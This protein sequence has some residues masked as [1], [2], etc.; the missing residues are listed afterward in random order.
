MPKTTAGLLAAIMLATT[1]SG[2]MAQSL[3]WRISETAGAV[4]IRHGT[5]ST[6]A[7][8][9]AML[10]P[11]DAVTTGAGGRAVLVH[12]RDFVTVSANSRVSVPIAEEAT[13][14]VKIVQDLGN[15][16]FKIQKLGVPHF[17]VKTPYLAAVV[18]GTTFSV[19]VDRAGTSLQVVEGAVEVATLD[20]GAR[21]LIR[22]GSVASI[23]AGDLFR[24]QVHGDGD[25]TI[26][27]PAR[28]AATGAATPVATTAV[29][30]SEPALPADTIVAESPAAPQEIGEA[31]S[32]KPIDLAAM[33]GGMMTG[34]TAAVSATLL[35]AV[36]ADLVR[37][38]APDPTQ[39][40][41]PPVAEPA[42]TPVAEAPPS[43]PPPE[44]ATATPPP[45]PAE[46]ASTP[47]PAPTSEVTPPPVEVAT[48]LPPPAPP[49]PPL[50]DP[51][52]GPDVVTAQPGN[53]AG[54]AADDA[55]KAADDAA[56]TADKA[57]KDAAKAA[58]DAAKA[59]DKAAKDAAKAADDVS[60]G[61]ADD[62]AKAAAKDAE[63][64]AKDAAKQAKDDALADL[65]KKLT[66]LGKQMSGKDD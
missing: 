5:T 8:R 47:P 49:P 42:A 43:A 50:V 41:A 31:I 24:L 7:T 44:V 37:P 27:S 1:S 6:P 29:A 58:D 15:A 63:K 16:I 10:A 45:P 66:K 35:A 20:G 33:T 51:T 3:T 48:A 22:P 30:S 46:V 61:K 12:D 56:K 59:A 34:S 55:K 64:A 65:V 52:K 25:R 28:A 11:G 23:G 32:S 2:A 53:D 21:D 13:G 40:A 38:V 54:K 36:K 4:A 17:G 14:F 19:T 9:G 57:A 18:K 62:A 39:P 60:K 26:D